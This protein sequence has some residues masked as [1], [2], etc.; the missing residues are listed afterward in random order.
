MN[1]KEIVEKW[2]IEN[3]YEGLVAADGGCKCE[4][5][6]LMRCY[7][8]RVSCKAG[9]IV[10]SSKNNYDFMITPGKAKSNGSIT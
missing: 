9:H 6:N 3:G 4:I 8:P 1:L 7:E 2:L 10:K 5:F